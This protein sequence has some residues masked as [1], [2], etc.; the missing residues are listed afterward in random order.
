LQREGVPKA[1]PRSDWL[2]ILCSSYREVCGV[3]LLSAAFNLN[4]IK[5]TIEHTLPGTLVNICNCL[6]HRVELK[7][8]FHGTETLYINMHFNLMTKAEFWEG[9]RVAGE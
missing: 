2:A 5:V 3:V 7:V 1:T 8:T 4:G 9:W 6:I